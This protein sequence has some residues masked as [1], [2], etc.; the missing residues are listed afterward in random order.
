MPPSGEKDAQPPQ[1]ATSKN[2]AA[3]SRRP[4]KASK[5]LV[6]CRIR[7]DSRFLGINFNLKHD[8]RSAPREQTHFES[9]HGRGLGG[10]S[11]RSG[12]RP[13]A[14]SV[15]AGRS[16]SRTMTAL[17]IAAAGGRMPAKN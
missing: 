14:T 8:R 11:S 17:S 7:A 2:K 4:R 1:A 16:V 3:S 12:W 5:F 10:R 15:T 9:D 6:E 13:S